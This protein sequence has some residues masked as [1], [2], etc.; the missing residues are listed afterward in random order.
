MGLRTVL[1]GYKI[2]NLQFTIIPEEADIVR[3]IFN[4]YITGKT[5]KQ[6]ADFLT[7]NKTVY[8]KDKC[9]WTKNA[10]CRILENEHYA[11]DYDY[12][13]II[14]RKDYEK[15]NSMK[16]QKGC[17]KAADTPEIVFLK[18]NTICGQCGHRLTRRRNY[19]GTRERW[20]CL[21]HCKIDLFLDDKLYFDKMC[22]ILNSVIRNPELLK[23]KSFNVNQYEATLDIIR[24]DK[25]IDRMLEQKE[26][27][28][29][30]IKSAVFEA[31]SA[32]F[33]CC[34]LDYSK[35]ITQ[36]LIN[37]MS[38]QAPTKEID[39]DLFKRVAR[40]IIVYQDGTIGITF[41]NDRTIT[42]QEA[43]CNGNDTDN[44]EGSNEN[45]GKSVVGIT[46]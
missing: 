16:S 36:E 24:R 45:C 8:Y 4:D 33:D 37:F 18:K 3:G 44:A 11:G 17:K 32:R 14:K 27:K 41:I 42:E 26:P 31:A 38:E 29:M 46:E 28:F 40:S 9:T 22:S 6:I 5:M 30:P 2:E 12:P 34:K 10:I 20:E 39:F 13:A 43:I 15:A 23:H 25:E 7:A 19:S 1:Y 35:A 21:N